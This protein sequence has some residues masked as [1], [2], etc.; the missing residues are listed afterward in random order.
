MIVVLLA[1]AKIE[2]FADPESTTFDRFSPRLNKNATALLCEWCDAILLA[3]RERGAAK[4]EKCL[5]G[6]VE[7]DNYKSLTAIALADGHFLITAA[8]LDINIAKQVNILTRY[9][10]MFKCSKC[11]LFKRFYS[12]LK[13]LVSVHFK[14]MVSALYCFN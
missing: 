12:N 3:T 11:C 4:G 7:E 2:K 13:D 14:V 6:I 5:I 8:P 1:H 10:V 9:I